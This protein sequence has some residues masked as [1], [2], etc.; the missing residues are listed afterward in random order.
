MHKV[1]FSLTLSSSLSVSSAAT[2]GRKTRHCAFV[3]A[4]ASGTRE[5]PFPTARAA[6]NRDVPVAKQRRI[7]QELVI[8][9]WAATNPHT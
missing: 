3:F 2:G 4:A 7:A 8:Y 9:A 6:Y 1:A 5:I